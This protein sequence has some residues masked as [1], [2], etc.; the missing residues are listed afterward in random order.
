MVRK[1]EKIEKE[2][3]YCEIKL[4]KKRRLR[5]QVMFLDAD[6]EVQALTGKRVVR[7]EGSGL[8]A[9]RDDGEYLN[10]TLRRLGLQLHAHRQIS[11]G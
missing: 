2:M 11:D 1:I 10:L 7:I 3:G 8:G 5:R 4:E 9:N 6:L